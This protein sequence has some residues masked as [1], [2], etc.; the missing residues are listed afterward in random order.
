V[1]S[2]AVLVTGA[3]GLV[4][5]ATV[6]QVVTDG[7][8][9]VAVDLDTAATRKVA[10]TLPAEADIRY[11]DLTDG[12][13]VA[14][15]IN[16]VDPV[17]IIHL[18]ALIPP[19]IYTRRDVAHTVNVGATAALLAAAQRQPIPPRFVLASS[20]AVYGARNPYRTNDL[21]TA[22]TPVNP[23]DIYGAHKVEAEKL[24]QA[25]EL[26]WVILRLGGILTVEPNVQSSLDNIYLERL[27]PAD[28]RVQTVDVRD[29]ARAFVAATTADCV[30]ETL[31]IGGDD[32]THR[33]RQGDVGA[34]MAAAMGLVNGF[35]P[36]LQ[37]DPN[38]DTD[39]YNT[40]WMDTNRAEEVLHFQQHSWPDM[41]AEVTR[42]TGWKRGLM[43]LVAP[44]V[45]VMLDR[46][47]AYHGSGRTYADPWD[48][49]ATKWGDPA[50]TSQERA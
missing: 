7:R 31:L 20:V 37:G 27:L 34:S 50:P 1:P 33:H 43:R 18:A 14:G 29:V 8:H 47:S 3:C 28:G 2:D 32:T 42:K 4:G 38:S 36:G 46:R 10:A 9:V 12:H 35:P 45:R 24:V 11:A 26:R 30:G 6:R 22:D 21:L 19:L 17:A 44:L 15:L 40:D 16:A 39:W 23:A 41:L 49:I 48:G 13:A 5:A 25:A